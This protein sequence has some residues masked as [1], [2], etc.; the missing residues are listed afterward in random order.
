M[1]WTPKLTICDYQNKDDPSS[2]FVKISY[3]EK[4]RKKYKQFIARYGLKK[5]KREAIDILEQKRAK[6]VKQLTIGV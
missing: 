5:T 3:Y 4:D 1:V 6:L 2:G